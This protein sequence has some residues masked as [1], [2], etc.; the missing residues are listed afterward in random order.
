MVQLRERGARADEEVHSQ[1]EEILRLK[2]ELEQ[3]RSASP[4]LAVDSDGPSRA[5]QV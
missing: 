2:E 1:K 3:A 5:G 4:G